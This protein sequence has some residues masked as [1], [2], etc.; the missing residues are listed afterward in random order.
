MP[1]GSNAETISVTAH[2]AI[3]D[4][5]QAD[6]DACAAP[7]CADG[8]RPVDPFTTHRF[9]KALEDSG[10]VSARTGWAPRHLSARG[11][12]GAILGVMP[13]YLKSHSQG[14]YV[15]DHAW[16]QAWERAGG[17]YYPKLQCAVPFT[18]ATGRRLLAHPAA[19]GDAVEAALLQAAAQL[20]R[21]ADIS[22]LHVTF[23]TRA[24]WERGRALG[25]LQRQDQQFHWENNG[26]RDYADFLDALASRKRKQ[27]RR[28]RAEAVSDGVEIVHLTGEALEPEHWDAFWVFYQDTGARKWGR[29]YL[30]RRFF[31]I[32]QERLRHDAL[33]V[34]CR[35]EGR[36]IAGALNFIGRRTLF[37]R[38]WGCVEDRPF[39]HFEACYHQ[40]IDAAMA[41]GLDRVEAGAQGAHKLARGYMPTPTYS[42]HWIADAGFRRA[43]SDYLARERQAVGEDIAFMLERGPFRKGD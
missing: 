22:S 15:F 4:I 6:W 26:Y 18:P 33:L 16:A 37:G 13:L 14:E 43:V 8:G 10:S 41:M 28:E 20:A 19:P 42:L 35:R 23:C 29:P 27:L 17:A 24:E 25:L 39:L 40:A 31:D 32:V 36:W 11:G 30:T 2:A 9:L 12:D 5:P 34:M 38:Y 7:E 3:D 21:R 1:D